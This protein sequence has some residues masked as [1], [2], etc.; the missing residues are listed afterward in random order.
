MIQNFLPTQLHCCRSNY[1]L[2]PTRSLL[3]DMCA[4]T[5][6]KTNGILSHSR[7]AHA[8]RK[9]EKRK[10]GFNG[11]SEQHRDRVSRDLQSL[12]ADQESVQSQRSHSPKKKHN[13]WNDKKQQQRS[14][15]WDDYELALKKNKILSKTT[16]VQAIM[17][18]D[19]K[20]FSTRN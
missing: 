20:F 19:E 6:R 14:A 15:W 10:W 4:Q 3:P 12:R 7:L 16:S 17:H 13:T 8:R 11:C 18:I 9:L 2:L 5:E 1:L